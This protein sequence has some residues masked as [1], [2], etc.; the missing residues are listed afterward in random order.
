MYELQY[1]NILWKWEKNPLA[2][3]RKKGEKTQMKMF[4]RKL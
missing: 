3:N 1:N 2:K 4:K